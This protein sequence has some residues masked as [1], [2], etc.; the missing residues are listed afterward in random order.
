MA[1]V[2]KEKKSKHAACILHNQ[3][4]KKEGKRKDDI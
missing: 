3:G 4:A 1:S 2:R